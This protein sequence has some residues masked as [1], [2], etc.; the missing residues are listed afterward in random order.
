MYTGDKGKE[1]KLIVM[2]MADVGEGSW[3][4]RA[5][6]CLLQAGHERTPD[7][8]VCD[9]LLEGPMLSWEKICGNMMSFWA[10]SMRNRILDEKLDKLRRLRGRE[11]ARSA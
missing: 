5:E 1:M 10:G 4:D 2:F 3:K 8:K 11:V 7:T 9:R 6:K